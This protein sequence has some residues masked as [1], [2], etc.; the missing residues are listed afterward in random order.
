MNVKSMKYS[1]R[2]Y[3]F[4]ASICHLCVDTVNATNAV[5]RYEEQYPVFRDSRQ[6]NLI[7]KLII[8]SP[9]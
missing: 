7:K 6:S 1:A 9:I 2:E 8:V 5:Q 4:R 3:C